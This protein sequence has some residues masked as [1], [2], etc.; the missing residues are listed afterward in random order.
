MKYALCLFFIFFCSKLFPA[1]VGNP[2]SPALIQHGLFSSQSALVNF[3]SGY[4]YSEAWDKNIVPKDTPPDATLEKVADF[5]MKSSFATLALNILRRLELYSY[6]GV[7]KENIDWK[8]KIPFTSSEIKTKNHF[9]YSVGAKAIMLQFGGTVFSLDFQYFILPSSN[10]L[11]PKIVSIYMPIPEGN[12]YL[13]MKEWQ[14][15]GGIAVKLGPFTP[16]GGAKYSHLRLQVKSTEGIPN[17]FFKNRKNW[18]LFAGASLNFGPLLVATFEMRFVDEKA[19][20][21]AVA[22]A[23]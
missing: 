17:L 20:S 18:G 5:E 14:I 13:K 3:S 16:Y 23:F 10:K 6:L 11:I 7:S 15:S 4:L 1:F 12:Q 8:A 19:F 21:A 9:S 22:T 2:Y